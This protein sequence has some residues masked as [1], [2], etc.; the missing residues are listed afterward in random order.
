[1]LKLR[2]SQF[3]FSAKFLWC[4]FFSGTIVS[5]IL[6]FTLTNIAFAQLNG[7][8]QIPIGNPGANVTIPPECQ[9]GTSGGITPPFPKGWVSSRLDM[10]FDGTFTDKIV[11]P[12][13]GKIT[14]A[15]NSFSNWGGYIEI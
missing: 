10:G 15:A 2:I 1:M 7:C 11:A 4:S 8:A 5:V 3:L 13:D 14:Y 9:E 6:F 12:F